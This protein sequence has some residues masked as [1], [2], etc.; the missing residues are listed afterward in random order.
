MSRFRAMAIGLTVAIIVLLLWH[1][2]GNFSNEE[3]TL[4]LL[5]YPILV[6]DI[7]YFCFALA[8]S[9]SVATHLFHFLLTTDKP[10]SKDAVR[11]NW[12]NSG[13]ISALIATMG[14]AAWMLDTPSVVG[15][16]FESRHQLFAFLSAQSF[17]FATLATIMSSIS[18]TFTD[19]LD[20][21]QFKILF[22]AF[23]GL[24]GFP[25]IFMIPSLVSLLLALIYRNDILYGRPSSMLIGVLA[26][27][28]VST[29]C[30]QWVQLWQFTKSVVEASSFSR[31]QTM[32]SAEEA[33]PFSRGQTMQLDEL[34]HP[35][36][37]DSSGRVL[38]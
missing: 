29:L 26:A 14:A 38:E 28:A 12:T 2:F 27:G 1:Q 34:G 5:L 22:N 13:V 8:F 11:S 4:F 32:K 35:C 17:I 18:L 16:R 21:G 30:Y 19:D 20:D 10:I 7:V 25:L 3:N 33:S 31:A 37:P 6:I 24:V 36:S 15:D 23:K 9:D